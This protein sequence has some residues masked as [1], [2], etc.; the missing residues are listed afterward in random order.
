M[1]IPHSAP[2]AVATAVEADLVLAHGTLR[3]G[4]VPGARRCRGGGAAST[5]SA[6]PCGAYAR[7][8]EQGWTVAGPAR[9]P[10]RR[11][12]APRRDRGAAGLLRPRAPCA[13]GPLA[14]RR[15]ADPRG[16]QAAF[17]MADAFGLRHVH[18]QRRFRRHP[19]AGRG[20]G[21]RRPCATGRREHGAARRPGAGAVQHRPRPRRPRCASSPRPAGPTAAS[22]STAGT[23]TAAAATSGPGRPAGRAASSSCSSTTGRVRPSTPTTSSTRCTTAPCPARAS[24]R[25]SASA[26][27]SRAGVQRAGLGRGAQRRARRA[28][29]GGVGGARR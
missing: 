7:L 2:R 5:G 26:A 29:S 18:G 13:R 11:G 10:G 22:A 9:G 12:R 3:Q 17:A 4:V 1:P 24:S 6:W 28:G 23:S 16:E 27:L 19:R 21:V 25:C 15:Y 20:G 14:G 8:R